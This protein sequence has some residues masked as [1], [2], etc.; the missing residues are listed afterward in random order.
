MCESSVYLSAEGDV[1]L[2]VMEEVGWMESDGRRIVLK[3]MAG[4]EKVIEGR[5]K[6]ADLVQHRIVLEPVQV[7]V[8]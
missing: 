3:D 1:E 2:L 7:E 4:Q 6:Y 8:Q 5:L